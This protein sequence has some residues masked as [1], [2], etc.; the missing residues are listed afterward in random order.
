MS[1]HKSILVFR[2]PV[3]LPR[4]VEASMDR[5]LEYIYT[6]ICPEEIPVELVRDV[7][8]FDSWIER[9]RNFE[10]RLNRFE[11]L[12][13]TLSAVTVFFLPELIAF[14]VMLAGR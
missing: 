14:V 8:N 10:V 1:E 5:I 6:E 3:A 13:M 12:V 9:V 2:I 7:N 11:L 4:D